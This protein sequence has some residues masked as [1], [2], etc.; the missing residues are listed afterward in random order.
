VGGAILAEKSGYDILPIAHNAGNFWP[1]GQFY[2][3]PGTVKIVIG[4][5]I[6]NQGKKSKELLK[7]AQTWIEEEVA[8]LI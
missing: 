4:E 3:T 8:S 1:K 6:K 7:E 5:P 2:K